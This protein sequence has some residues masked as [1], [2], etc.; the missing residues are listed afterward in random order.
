MTLRRRDVERW[1]KHRQLP[2]ELIR[3][4]YVLFPI[5]STNLYLFFQFP[6]YFWLNRINGLIVIGL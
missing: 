1:M 6:E 5:Y 2:E 4:L 3:L